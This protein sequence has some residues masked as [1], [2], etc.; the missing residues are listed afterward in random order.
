MKG[1]KTVHYIA[2]CR[3]CD[4]TNEDYRR[5]GKEAGKHHKETGHK[6]DLEIGLWREIL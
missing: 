4:W 6:I 3:D 1:Y 5:A 2:H